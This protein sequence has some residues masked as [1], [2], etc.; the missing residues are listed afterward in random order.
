MRIEVEI[1]P[2]KMMRYPTLGDFFW[3]DQETLR[4]EIADT[5][6]DLFN[7]MILLHEIKEEMLT[8]AR[9]L[10]EPEILDYDLKH[11][12]SDDPGMEVDAPYHK[13]HLFSTAD[14]MLM[15][16]FLGIPWSVYC[17]TLAKCEEGEADD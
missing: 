7:E 8:R 14:E 11:L 4:F 15:C 9:G 12:G 2:Y 16:S 3:R 10:T 1:K 6:N 5:G 13:E 17:K